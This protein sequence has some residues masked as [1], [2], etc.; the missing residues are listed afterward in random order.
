MLTIKSDDIISRREAYAAIIKNDK[1]KSPTIPAAF[2]VILGELKALCLNI[3][4]KNIS[5]NQE[6]HSNH[7][8]QL[9]QISK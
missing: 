4:I 5:K 3:E 1:I 6:E 2:N 8:Q 9:A 7:L